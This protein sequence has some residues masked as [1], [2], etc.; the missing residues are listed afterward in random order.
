[1]FPRPG[2]GRTEALSHL[3]ADG[4]AGE[5]AKGKSTFAADGH[6]CRA[7][8][9][10]VWLQCYLIFCVSS[11]RTETTKVAGGNLTHTSVDGRNSVAPT[12]AC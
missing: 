5:R 3:A 6:K 7:R 2:F 10:F 8:L 12:A 9:V 1:M 11:E 4:R